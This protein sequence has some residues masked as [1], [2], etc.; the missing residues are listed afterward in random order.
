MANLEST[1][2]K[3]GFQTLVSIGTTTAGGHPS[4]PLLGSL[5]N[6]KGNA[7]TQVTLANGTASQPAYSFTADPD[8]R[9]LAMGES[10]EL[11][12]KEGNVGIG[13]S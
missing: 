8:A 9:T 5:T 12:I 7:L 11:V 10:G 3:D 13:T 2:L 4:D 1:Q 6:G